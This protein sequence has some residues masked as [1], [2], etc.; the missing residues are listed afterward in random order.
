MGRPLRCPW[1]G[2]RGPRAP[3]S[4][5]AG[6]WATG[7]AVAAGRR[8]GSRTAADSASRLPARRRSGRCPVPVGPSGT[9][10]ADRGKHPGPRHRVSSHHRRERSTTSHGLAAHRRQPG[11]GAACMRARRRPIVPTPHTRTPTLPS[12]PTRPGP[13]DN[14]GRLRAGRGDPAP[15]SRAGRAPPPAG[16]TLHRHRD[17]GDAPPCRGDRRSTDRRGWSVA[18]VGGDRE[19]PH[20]AV[21]QDLLQCVD[22]LA[23][24]A[25]I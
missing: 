25:G 21:E 23:R 16:R 8:P 1:N 20:A 19:C 13:R 15:A 2:P 9:A 10:T 17:H 4:A 22:R 24:P 5:I 11:R 3:P 12:H 14:C 6:P 18:F 7:S